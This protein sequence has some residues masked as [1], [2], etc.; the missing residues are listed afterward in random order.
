MVELTFYV[1]EGGIKGNIPPHHNNKDITLS[2]GFII[3]W[4]LQ[5]I[6]MYSN[7]VKLVAGQYNDLPLQAL[8]IIHSPRT[9]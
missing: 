8:Y 5:Q 9:W 3:T 4:I 1:I 6:I 7:R 2:N